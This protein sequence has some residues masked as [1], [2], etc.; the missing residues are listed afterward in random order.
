MAKKQAETKALAVPAKVQPQQTLAQVYAKTSQS[1]LDQIEQV[2]A[3]AIRARHAPGT[4]KTYDYWVDR[5]SQWLEDPAERYSLKSTPAMNLQMVFS[6]LYGGGEDFILMWIFDVCVGPLDPAENKVWAED[7]GPIAPSTLGVIESA[8]ISYAFDKGTWK[9]SST[10]KASLKGIRNRLRDA[11]AST[12][13]AHP[14]VGSALLKMSAVLTAATTPAATRDRLVLELLGAG[15]PLAGINRLRFGSVLHPEG[16][17]A[18]CSH[19]ANLKLFTATGTVGS[20]SL[21]VPGQTRRGGHVDPGQLRTLSAWPELESALDAHIGFGAVDDGGAG[22]GDYLIK[23]G[24]NRSDVLRKIVIRLGRTAAPSW[25]PG[26]KLS[27][28]DAAAIRAE[29]LGTAANSQLRQRRDHAMLLCGW[30]LALRRS[31]LTALRL[32]DI[33][34]EKGGARVSIRKSKTNPSKAVLPLKRQHKPGHPSP[35]GTLQEWCEH[36]V[37][38]GAGPETPLFP[39]I[40]RHGKIRGGIGGATPMG[41]QVWSDRLE[42]IARAANCFTEEELERITGHSLRR[43]F[44]T[45]A[46]LQGMALLVLAKHTRHKNIAMLATYADE[47]LLMKNTDWAALMYGEDAGVIEE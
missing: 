24:K 29:L 2:K 11:S 15:V 13:Q 23:L 46:I 20:R 27:A 33:V 34:F 6:D 4:I 1:D 19:K 8:L 36:L 32:S 31:E 37:A 38:L 26:D 40:N 10:T 42:Q 12:R 17:T 5:F 35:A 3:K 41:D 47:V 43:G 21:L 14:I 16:E 25:K 45:H 22:A 44:V 30:W 39:A 9:P 18:V 28:K 7:T